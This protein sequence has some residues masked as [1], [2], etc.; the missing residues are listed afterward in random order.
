MALSARATT[1]VSTK[2]QVI[3]P[4]AIRE[5]RNWSA[6]T[7]LSVEDTPEGV[8]L[9]G[10]APFAAARPDDVFGCLAKP[11]APKTL[12]EMDAAITAEARRR[13]ARDRY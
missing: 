12:Q 11:G 5:R 6:G 13:D 8:L 7:R 10:L 9:R 2:G 1:R 3:L 4:K